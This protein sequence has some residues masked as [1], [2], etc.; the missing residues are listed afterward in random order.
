MADTSNNVKLLDTHSS[1][2]RVIKAWRI[3][4]C[5]YRICWPFVAQI[6]ALDKH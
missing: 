3:E 4:E 2:K 1:A 5:D 6:G